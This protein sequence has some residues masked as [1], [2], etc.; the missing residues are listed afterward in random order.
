MS[1]SSSVGGSRR[2]SNIVISLRR[3]KSSTVRLLR[4]KRSTLFTFGLGSSAADAPSALSDD[5]E[6]SGA[7]EVALAFAVVD[8]AFAAGEG[9]T[10]A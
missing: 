9:G 8:E 10:F 4:N 5:D 7:A 2:L 3:R 1:S 6:D